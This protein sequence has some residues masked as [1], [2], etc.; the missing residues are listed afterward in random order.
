MN[1]IFLCVQREERSWD[2]LFHFKFLMKAGYHRNMHF[3][4]DCSSFG[5]EGLVFH[6]SNTLY[7]ITHVH[8]RRKTSYWSQDVVGDLVF[9]RWKKRSGFLFSFL[10]AQSP[11]WVCLFFLALENSQSW[12]QKLGSTVSRPAWA[13]YPSLWE[14][15]LYQMGPRIR[16]TSSSLYSGTSPFWKK[17]KK[18]HPSQSWL[19]AVLRL[20]KDARRVNETE[21]YQF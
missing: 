2:L 1:F 3:N 18:H 4:K 7:K 15:R 10:T 21:I 6:D 19:G 13:S 9:L 11:L 17:K 14:E 5:F 8:G 12:S 20:F 16:S